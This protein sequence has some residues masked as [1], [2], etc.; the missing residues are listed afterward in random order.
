MKQLKVKTIDSQYPIYVGSNIVNQILKYIPNVEQYEQFVIVTDENVYEYY[1][2]MMDQ[3][4]YQTEKLVET[5]IIPAGDENKCLEIYDHVITT[6][7]ERFISRK[8][9][10]I[11]FGG[12]MIGDFGGF[13]A[14][15]YMRGIDFIQVP[16][17][18]LAHDSS[19]G[20]KVALN[21]QLAKNVI[22]AFYQPKAVLYDVDLLQTLPDIEWLSGYAEVLKHSEID[23]NFILPEA[24]SL[25]DVKKV[26]MYLKDA[27]DVKR[28]IVERDPLEQGE[29]IFLNY[30]HT[31]GHAL[32]QYFNYQL[33]HGICVLYGLIFVA[34]LEQR[35]PEKYYKVLSFVELPELDLKESDLPQLITYMKRDKKQSGEFSFLL[36]KNQSFHMEEISEKRLLIAYKQFIGEKEWNKY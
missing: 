7:L 35:S 33:P 17:T 22:G 3:Q 27:I 20:G 4:M 2:E 16:T 19:V 6:L 1:G 24:N 12:G 13:V 18:L 14:S 28:K 11:A 30:G 34:L 26:E 15:T 29:R 32:E 23:S 8:S 21:H 31:F 9:L 25:D 5:I 10:L 36:K